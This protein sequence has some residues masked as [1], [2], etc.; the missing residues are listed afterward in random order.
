MNVTIPITRIPGTG[1]DVPLP[2]YATPGS[3]G[4]DLRA[5]VTGPVTIPPGAT[6]LIP[7]GFMIAIPEGFEGQVRPR[8]GLAVRHGIGILNAPGTIDSDYRGEVKVILTNFGEA[9]F[10]V[11]RGERVAQLVIAPVA[12]ATLSPT[13]KLGDTDRGPGG[14]GHTGR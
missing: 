14:F 7:C 5:A 1:D 4:M 11:N 9:P 6:S 3:S 13:D 10:T 2:G 8:S 12:R